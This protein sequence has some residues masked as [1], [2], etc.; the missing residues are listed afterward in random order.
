MPE[1]TSER[2]LAWGRTPILWRLLPK[3]NATVQAFVTFRFG[4]DAILH[5]WC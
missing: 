5:P 1:T 3:S 4:Q 2:H